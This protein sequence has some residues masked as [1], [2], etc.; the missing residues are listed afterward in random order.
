MFEEI[1]VVIWVLI[2]IWGFRGMTFERQSNLIVFSAI[3][4]FYTYGF[5]IF[6]LW[7]VALITG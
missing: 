4:G 3:V 2:S 5:Y 7:I 1:L 6:T